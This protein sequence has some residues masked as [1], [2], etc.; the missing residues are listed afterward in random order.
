M[1][2]LKYLSLL[3]CLF[4]L[5]ACSNTAETIEGNETHHGTTDYPISV[6]VLNGTVSIE[7]KPERVI[8]LAP[9]VTEI[10]FAVGA[11]D[12]TVG[13]TEYSNY[14]EEALELPS[15]GGYSD[16]N[17]ESILALDPDL[18]IGTDTMDA[19]IQDQ[20][21]N[22]G[23]KVLLYDSNS[24]D[25]VLDSIQSIGYVMDKN[26]MANE[27]VAEMK[28]QFTELEED[29][30]SKDSE[31]TV[32]IDIG[33]FYTVGPNSF[34]NNELELIG[35]KNIAT[36]STSDY[37]VLTSEAIIAANPDVYISLYT[38]LDDLKAIPGFDTMNCFKNDQVYVY[39]PESVQADVIQRP[40]PRIVDGIYILAQDIYPECFR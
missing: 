20:L 10:M 34:I 35:A 3:F 39:D 8:S 27:L 22:A 25:S 21:E 38:S 7:E 36:D 24:V 15:V 2:F 19:N 16:P 13:R 23:I 1:K 40:G 11:E 37:P 18:V 6:E 28:N 30:A 33:D 32:F 26:D 31:K 14:P 9:S 17:I 5:T 29:L 4:L 12:E